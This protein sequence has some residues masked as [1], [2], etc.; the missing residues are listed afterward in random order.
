[1]QEIPANVKE[2]LQ[3]T[4]VRWIDQVLD[5]A[6]ERQ[7]TPLAVDDTPAP[8]LEQPKAISA[9]TAVRH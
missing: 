5:I 3:I 2:G 9:A 7:P 6:L 8:A 4:P 1:L